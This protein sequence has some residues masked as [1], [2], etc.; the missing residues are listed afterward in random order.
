M[1]RW[2]LDKY[3]PLLI[4]YKGK[5]PKETASV[6]GLL[7]EAVILGGRLPLLIDNRLTETNSLGCSSM[8][9]AT[10]K[11]ALLRGLPLKIV[12]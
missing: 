12:A 8:K 1:V 9:I 5:H 10:K 6:N 2:A 7:K 11:V 4:I 3:P